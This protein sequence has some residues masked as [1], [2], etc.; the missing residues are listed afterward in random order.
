M[1]QSVSGNLYWTNFHTVFRFVCTTRRWFWI[2]ISMRYGFFSCLD[3][4]Q[5]CKNQNQNIGNDNSE[6]G[7]VKWKVLVNLWIEEREICHI[8]KRWRTHQL[9]FKAKVLLVKWC[10]CCCVVISLPKQSVS[11]TEIESTENAN[12]IRL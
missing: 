4:T 5:K 11:V 1:W 8:P 9:D 10:C 6:E 3:W 12:A 7:R 2:L